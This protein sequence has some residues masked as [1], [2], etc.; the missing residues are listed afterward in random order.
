MPH[1]D[2]FSLAMSLCSFAIC[3]CRAFSLASTFA[4]TISRVVAAA[5]FALAAGAAACAVAATL[6]ARLAGAVVLAAATL[7]ATLAGAVV[8]AGAGPAA[9]SGAFL[10]GA[11]ES[12][13]EKRQG[14]RSQ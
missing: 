13:G 14:C 2:E 3:A 8:L 6:V 9:I 1:H 12:T 11:L 4:G 7:V 10:A 5:D